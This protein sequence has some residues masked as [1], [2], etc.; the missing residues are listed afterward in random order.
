MQLMHGVHTCTRLIPRI[1]PK[2]AQTKTQP[3]CMCGKYLFGIH[4]VQAG[5]GST[6]DKP[7]LR[8]K[9]PKEPMLINEIAVRRRWLPSS[10]PRRKVKKQNA[11][12]HRTLAEWNN[13]K[14]YWCIIPSTHAPFK[15]FYKA[16]VPFQGNLLG[17]LCTTTVSWQPPST[18]HLRNCSCLLF[19]PSTAKANKLQ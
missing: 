2:A 10:L 16:L 1:W 5:A 18:S 14:L 6:R 12:T 15:A 7:R 13:T 9:E 3:V 8:R 4:G 19:S 17:P 11:R